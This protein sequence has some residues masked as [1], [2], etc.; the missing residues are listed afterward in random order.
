MNIRV[1]IVDDEPLA[2]RRLRQLLAE[3]AGVDVAG[4]ARNAAEAAALCAKA[5]PDVLLLDIEMP[6]G[7]GMELLRT[8]S[9]Q[10]AVIF[11]TAHA[12]F[13]VE[14]FDLNAV[15]YLLKPVTPERLARA[16]A[17]L[18]QKLV[19]AEPAPPAEESRERR[20]GRIALRTRT[21]IVFIDTREIEW[22]AAEGN[23]SRI[24]LRGKSLLIRELL[25]TLGRQLDPDLFVRVHRSAIVHVERVRKVVVDP[26]GGHSAVL[27]S[28]AQVRIG[29]SHRRNLERLLGELF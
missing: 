25:S 11:I 27:G 17:R 23:Y 24:H 20:R 18:R 28:G 14:A 7:N 22:I 15:D 26:Q 21:E 16:Q 29:D 2:R 10:P 19:L 3:C 4:E 5:S 13:A 12:R 9:P 8:L 1:A 6:L